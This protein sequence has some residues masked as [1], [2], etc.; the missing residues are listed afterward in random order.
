MKISKVWFIILFHC[1]VAVVIMWVQHGKEVDAPQ[2]V[3]A[4]ANNNLE[5]TNKTLAIKQGQ[6]AQVPPAI[7]PASSAQQ[8]SM[9]ANR[10]ELQARL[11]QHEGDF[12]Q[13]AAVEQEMK[14]TLPTAPP[15]AEESSRSI[16]K[17]HFEEARLQSMDALS[18]RCP[19]TLNV[20]PNPA[21]PADIKR[22]RVWTGRDNSK[23]LSVAVLV[24]EALE[25]S[26]VSL[27]ASVN[28]AIN[29]MTNKG[30]EPKQSV[31]DMKVSGLPAKRCSFSV[32]SHRRSLH[33]EMMAIQNAKTIYIVQTMFSGEDPLGRE[34]ATAIVDS[35]K[36][37]PD[38]P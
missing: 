17:G 18:V 12:K 20:V 8:S 30:G 11:R 13:L 4:A 34:L 27:D 1:I 31:L 10:E 26:T 35:A 33:M 36:V 29:S 3:V 25:T 28:G 2:A 14:E 38:Q 32:V 15:L 5:E 16:S 9:P 6:L 7:A 19:L 22:L 23:E 24:L 37:I 21:T